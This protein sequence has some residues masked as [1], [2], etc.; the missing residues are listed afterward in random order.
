MVD[1]IVTC[2]NR[3]IS[4]VRTNDIRTTYARPTNEN[5]IQAVVG[6]LLLS[7]IQKSNKLNFSNL[8]SSNGTSPKIFRLALSEQRFRLSFDS[9]YENL[10]L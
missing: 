10:S 6:M 9:I 8:F 2:T 1:L 5:E 4:R 7:G 3:E